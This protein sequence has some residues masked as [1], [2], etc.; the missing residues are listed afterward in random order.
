[1]FLPKEGS[2]P[3][4]PIFPFLIPARSVTT[5][6]T[7]LVISESSNASGM[8]APKSGPESKLLQGRSNPVQVKE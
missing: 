2:Q 3:R 8:P 6:I 7:G 5:P 4:L 1:M